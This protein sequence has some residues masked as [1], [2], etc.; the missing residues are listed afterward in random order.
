MKMKKILK[1][2]I[3]FLILQGISPTFAS[4]KVEDVFVD[5][6]KDYIYYNEIQNLYDKW[7]IRPDL[8]GKFNP[9]KL[10][11][12]DEF[13]WI[14]MEVW[15]TKCIQPYVSPEYILKYNNQKTFYDVSN[16]NDY[17]YC[18]A[19]A[20]VKDVVKWYS[21]S[22]VC[23]DGT[24]KSWEI[25]FCTN[26]NI[27]LEEA[28]AFLL[29]NSSVFTIQDNQNIITQIQTWL[30]TQN[31]LKDV[32]IKNTDG[33]VYTFYWYFQKALQLNYSEYDIYGKEKKYQFIQMDSN[34][35]LNPKQYITKQDF[36]KMAYV[37][38]KTNS[39][40]WEYSWD[41]DTKIWLQIKIYDKIC[42][43]DQTNCKKSEWTDSQGIY[44]FQ[45]NISLQCEKG[46]KDVVWTFY[47]KDTKE[48]LVANQEYLDN[49]KLPSKGNWVVRLVAQDSCWNQSSA[50]VALSTSQVLSLQIQATHT[51]GTGFLKTGFTS[52]TNCQ[53]CNYNWDFWDGKKSQDKNPTHTFEK[54]GSYNVILKITDQNGNTA[55]SKISIY[56]ANILNDK[57]L[58]LEKEL[59]KNDILDEIKNITNQDEIKQKLDEL[60]KEIWKNPLLDEIK[61][62]L[63]QSALQNLSQIDT[64]GDG[65]M[66]DVDKCVNIFGSKDNFWCPILDKQCLINSEI[67]TCWTGYMCNS[68]WYCEIKTQKNITS[69][70][71]LPNNDSSIFWNLLCNSCPCEYSFDFLATLRKCDVVIPAIVSPDGKKMYGKWTPYEIPYEYK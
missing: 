54:A 48:N 57:I 17:A 60:E 3:F 36:L 37:I 6:K 41:T 64:D 8:D 66:D 7:V 38:S 49:Y 52:I 16:T 71:I 67:D 23:Q 4:E 69:S 70:C 55:Q 11:S 44:D 31:L 28:V 26:N 12:R 35:N 53:N 59:W 62:S 68:K 45:A 5:I 58:E 15:C 46:I 40:A 32:G 30:I 61:S 50:E 65:V 43:P 27:T 9:N 29:R 19:D 20:Y 34:G 13:I 47:N 21:P 10:L 39:C 51:S 14:A 25:P 42:T 2:I 18:I 24:T 1:S 63:N 33:S 22:Y 56:V